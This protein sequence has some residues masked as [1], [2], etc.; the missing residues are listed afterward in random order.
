MLLGAVEFLRFSDFLRRSPP[1]DYVGPDN[2]FSGIS[3]KTIVSYSAFLLV[4]TWPVVNALAADVTSTWDNTTNNW[5]S[6]HWSS[7]MFPNNGNGG[8]TYDAEI[9]GGA[10]TLD[11]DITIEKF[12]LSGGALVGPT[13]FTLTLNDLFTWTG[14]TI[15]G[16]GNV[17]AGGGLTISGGTAKT[18]AGSRILTNNGTANFS[19]GTLNAHDS[20]GGPGAVLDNNGIFNATDEADIL[21]QNV[22]GG[23]QPSFSNDGTFNKSGAATT[24]NVSVIFNNTGTVNVDSGTL[25]L[26]AGGTSSGA[27]AV[28]AGTTLNFGGGTHSLSAALS[29]TSAGIVGFSGG[30][31]TIAGGYTATATT[32]NGGTVNFN[33]A[34]G[35]TSN[36]MNF[37]SG[38]LGG[39]G[40][41]TIDTGLL[42][43]TGGM[44][45]GSGTTTIAAPATLT[46][47]GGSAK[48]LY[49]SRVIINN[50]TTSLSGGN[51]HFHRSNS[52]APGAIFDNNNIFNVTD[53]ADIIFTADLGGN[54]PSF[55][56]DG[57]FN[58]SGA[59][60]TTDVSVA[61]NS[62]GTVNV[63][64]GTLRLCT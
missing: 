21:F 51:F 35:A 62:A 11:Q 64:S 22:V 42:A 39:S 9:G 50:G 57:A 61:F 30:T 18:L 46:L 52:A 43:W 40:P 6:A 15:G 13:S 24:T 26:N 33:A 37:S 54:D 41:L 14:G 36:S 34:G 7:A 10:V 47:S 60:T 8:F 49:D 58:K 23:T 31:T 53:D 1:A 5:T 16:V 63:N 3:M 2:L 59:G 38:V 55:S 28:D 44:M 29:I 25:S 12:T 4:L 48:H 32:I 45:T 27:F 56:N 17:S 20:G 19:G